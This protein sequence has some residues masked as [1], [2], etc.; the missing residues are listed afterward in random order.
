[1]LSRRDAGVPRHCHL[2]H[3]HALQRRHVAAHRSL[4]RRRLGG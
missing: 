2:Q 1:V 4:E 3:R